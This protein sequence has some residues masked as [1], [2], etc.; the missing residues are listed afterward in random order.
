MAFGTQQSGR[1]NNLNPSSGNIVD[2]A[3][4]EEF[5]GQQRI[6]LQRGDIDNHGLMWVGN[7]QCVEFRPSGAEV[8]CEQIWGVDEAVDAAI[9]VMQDDEVPSGTDFT[10]TGF[11][12]DAQHRHRLERCWSNA[13]ADIADHG[14]FSGREA[15][16]IDRIDAGI[17]A[18]DNH[19]LQRRYDLQVCGKA[20]AGEGLVAQGQGVNDTH[21]DCFF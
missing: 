18:T 9:G 19:R 12:D 4:D 3:A 21:W 8:L 5:P 13:A 15:E 7:C 14:G 1:D 16:Y 2:E 17:D 20:V 10:T 6:G 11:G